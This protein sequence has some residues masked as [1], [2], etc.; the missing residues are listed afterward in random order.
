MGVLTPGL[1]MRDPQLSPP[2]PLAEI[3][4]INFLSFFSATYFSSIRGYPRVMKF[5]TEFKSQTNKIAEKILLVLMGS[6]VEGQACAD[7]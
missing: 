3:F 7:P 4:D 1:R 5:C 2:S 6:R